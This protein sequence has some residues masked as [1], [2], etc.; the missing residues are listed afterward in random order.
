MKG[1]SVKKLFQH[2]ED[3]SWNNDIF[4]MVVWISLSLFVQIWG[5]LYKYLINMWLGKNRTL[6]Q[7]LGL[8]LGSFILMFAF[9]R[10]Y[11]IGIERKREKIPSA[12]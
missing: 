1:V 8:A 6:T 3:T 2:E 7:L 4:W 9:I 10:T 12:L 5:D 11:D